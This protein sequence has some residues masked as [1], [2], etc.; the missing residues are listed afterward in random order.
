M[1]SNFKQGE[2]MNLDEVIKKLTEIR[3][4]YGGSVL[5]FVNGENGAEDT[6]QAK[7]NH[8]DVG[9]AKMTIASDWENF[10]CLGINEKTDVVQIGGY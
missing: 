4:D 10:R 2:N 6:E 3:E 8:F 1:V 5:V 9:E 7:E